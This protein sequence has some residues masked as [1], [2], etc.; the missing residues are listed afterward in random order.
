MKCSGC[1]AEIDDDSVFCT[2]CG[3]KI[4]KI[5]EE[6]TG[7]PSKGQSK[8][9]FYCSTDNRNFGVVNCTDYTECN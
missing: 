5:K 9:T 8:R 3:K 7:K 2:E 6:V 1:E 4:E